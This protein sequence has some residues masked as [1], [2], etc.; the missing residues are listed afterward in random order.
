MARI[1]IEPVKAKRSV[2]DE[3]SLEK[4]LNTGGQ[5][6][7]EQYRVESIMSVRLVTARKEMA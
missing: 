1:H 3:Q 5:Q 6:C 4:K 2:Q 7:P